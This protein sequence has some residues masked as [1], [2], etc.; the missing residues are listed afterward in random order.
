MICK[1][2]GADVSSNEVFCPNCGSPLRVTADYDYIQ[3]EIGVKVDQF[4]KEEPD[5]TEEVSSP[6]DT[7]NGTAVNPRSDRTEPPLT[8]IGDSST[9][10]Q[11]PEAERKPRPRPE[12][13]NKENT[14]AITRTLYVKDSIFADEEARDPEEEERFE[15]ER[16]RNPQQA[17]RREE[18]EQA[19]KRKRTILIVVVVLV[20]LAAAAGVIFALGGG[21]EKKPEEPV[22]VI[23]CSVEEGGVYTTPIE[24][25]LWS[26]NDYRIVYTLDG[27]EPGI[28]SGTKYGQPISFTNK[29]VKKKGSEIVLTAYSYNN[30]IKAGELKVTFTLKR[31][32]IAEPV[33]DLESGDY[34]EPAYISISAEEGTTIYYTYDGSTPSENSTRYTGPIEMKRGNFVLSAIAVDESGVKSK[35]A[36]AV[37]NLEIPAL[38]SYD[39]A[40]TAVINQLLEEELI[41]SAEQ[42]KNGYYTVPGGGVRR[43][44]N[45][46]QALIGNDSF[47]VVQVDYM[48]DGSNVQATTYYG[49]NDQNGEVTRLNRSGMNFVLG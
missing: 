17:R 15:R 14:I 32:R 3:A 33:F 2:C 40:E 4:L 45:G 28:T 43:V 10:E 16:T 13:Q 49:V 27:S 1:E 12:T 36:S 7:Q 39:E 18:L 22:D 48:N 26:E 37:Y 47:Y 23:S 41:E 25:T 20:V 11:T 24:I 34:Y 31:S 6:F 8:I 42:D 46:G 44:L 38:I 29:D 35:A 21:A 19:K 9:E 30:S 5:G